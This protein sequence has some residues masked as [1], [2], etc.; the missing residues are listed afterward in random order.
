MPQSPASAERVCYSRQG[1]PKCVR[2][3]DNDSKHRMRKSCVVVCSPA[4][5]CDWMQPALP[6]HI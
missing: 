4:R 6:A 2:D 5:T 1:T 3:E